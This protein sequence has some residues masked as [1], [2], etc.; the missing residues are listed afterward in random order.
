MAWVKLDDR[1]DEHPKVAAL[2]DSAVALFVSGLAYCNRNLT[3]GFVPRQVGLGQ[4]RY[5]D[6]NTTPVIGE[7]VEAGMWEE[8]PGGWQVHDYLDFQPSRE[9]VEGDREAAR[10]RKAKSRA[11]SQRDT[12]VTHKPVTPPPV[13][14]PD[15]EEASSSREFTQWHARRAADAVRERQRR[16]LAVK[17]ERGL[18]KAISEDEEFVT[19]SKRLWAHRHHKTCRGSGFV[20]AYAPGAG[21]VRNPCTEGT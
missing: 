12:P 8:A 17:S 11:K 19:E 7:L 20:E 2:S 4:L 15:P 6:G 10:E 3:D 14:V 5:C 16:G 21:T 18:A 9:Q 13:P 1:F